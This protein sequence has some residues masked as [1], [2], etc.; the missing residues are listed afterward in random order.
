MES[1]LYSPSVAVWCICTL[2]CYLTLRT[3]YRLQF[4]PLHKIPGPRL[5]AATHLVEFYYDVVK[6]GKYIWEVERMHKRYGL[7]LSPIVLEVP[8]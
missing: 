3:I 2:A 4:H 8:F 6:G 5:A 7:Y 1:F